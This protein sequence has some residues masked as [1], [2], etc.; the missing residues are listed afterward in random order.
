MFWGDSVAE[1]REKAEGILEPLIERSGLDASHFIKSIA[2]ISGTIYDNK[3]LLDSNPEYL[4]NLLSQ[5]EQTRL[6]LL[7]GNWKVVLSEDDIY[8]YNDFL[9]M[10]ENIRNVD[11]KGKY[12][13]ADIALKG[14]NKL[15][16]GY[17]EGFELLN[18][19]VMAKS[20]GGQVIDL[21]SAVA[22]YYGVKNSNICFD[23]DGV[24]GYIDGFIRGALNFNGGT[25]ALEVTDP[26]SGKKIKENYFNLK[27]QCYYRSG[28]RV[29]RGDYKISSHVANHMY[30]DKYT[31]RQRFLFE[32]KAIKRD[33]AD[34]DGK[35]RI[36]SKAMMKAKLGGDS[37]DLMD[38]F[39]MREMF[40][41]IP[42]R[43]FADAEY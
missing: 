21:I 7:D 25:P 4:G 6:Q 30:D 15:V 3:K 1:V 10:F 29:G 43:V 39:M 16:V 23:S 32:R 8:N 37:P 9:G 26:A 31:V 17:W 38:M 22:Q 12:I 14:S 11:N 28:A 5:D 36:I 27:T 18:I 24:G 19:E 13:T 35:L 20:D 2:F 41:L 34:S 40:E 33:K 42:K